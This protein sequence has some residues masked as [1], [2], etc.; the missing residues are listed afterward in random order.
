MLAEI[1]SVLKLTYFSPYTAAIWF[2][3]PCDLPCA[4]SQQDTR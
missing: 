1:T 4:V 3:L 2:D